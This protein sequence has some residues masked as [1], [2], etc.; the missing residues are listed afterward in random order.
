M[1]EITAENGAFL[2]EVKTSELL[3]QSWFGIRMFQINNNKHLDKVPAPKK[4]KWKI[5]TENLNI[6]TLF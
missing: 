2:T 5:P 6:H 1:T 3:P 4:P